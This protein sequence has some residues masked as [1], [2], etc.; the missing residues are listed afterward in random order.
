MGLMLSKASRPQG[1]KHAVLLRKISTVPVTAWSCGC[2]RV[3]HT[4]S[5]LR[6]ILSTRGALAKLGKDTQA[7]KQGC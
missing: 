3:S 6:R 1:T 5:E 7:Y 4:S 2:S